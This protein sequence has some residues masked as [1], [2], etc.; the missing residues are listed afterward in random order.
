MSAVQVPGATWVVDVPGA[1]WVV[2]VPGATCVVDVPGATCAVDVPRT[3]NTTSKY[4]KGGGQGGGVRVR[5]A[6]GVRPG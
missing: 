5:G 4:G 2:D 1:T 6:S 3:Q